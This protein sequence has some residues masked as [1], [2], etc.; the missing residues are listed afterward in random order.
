[1]YLIKITQEGNRKI[2]IEVVTKT[3]FF[4]PY[5]RL[6][7]LESG[8][9]RLGMSALLHGEW[10]GT[11]K[12]QGSS[13]Q[14][15]ATMN[16]VIH[17]WVT[18][19]KISARYWIPLPISGMLHISQLY[20]GMY[21]GNAAKNKR[22]QTPKTPTTTSHNIWTGNKSAVEHPYSFNVK[23]KL[24]GRVG[25]IRHYIRRSSHETF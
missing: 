11:W 1:M 23:D 19:C 15:E 16:Q 3:F 20:T 10:T 24:F 21:F 2:T 18:C 8:S 5:M 6:N 9:S 12:S 25:G 22:K 4:F 13:G 17:I 14:G 7:F